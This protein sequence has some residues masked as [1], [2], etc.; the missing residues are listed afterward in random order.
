[1]ARLDWL[2]LNP[3]LGTIA[4]ERHDMMALCDTIT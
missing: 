4:F 1:M 3:Y 2:A